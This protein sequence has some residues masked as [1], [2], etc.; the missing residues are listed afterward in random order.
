MKDI[1]SNPHVLS[2]MTS[3]IGRGNSSFGQASLDHKN[4]YKLESSLF[5]GNGD[6]IGYPIGVLFLHDEARVD[7]LFDFRLDCFHYFWTKSLLLLFDW[8]RI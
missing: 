2:I 8:F 4:Q 5:V 1:R 7:E 6:D 3:V